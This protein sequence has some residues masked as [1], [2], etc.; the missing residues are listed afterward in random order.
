M[1]RVEAIK[2]YYESE[3]ERIISRHR[4]QSGGGYVS[5]REIM[6]EHTRL[7]DTVIRRLV[8][9][10]I[11]DAILPKDAALTM[12]AL[13]GYGREELNPHSDIDLL[14][15]YDRSGFPEPA[16][17]GTAK[18][19]VTDLWDVGFEVGNV[20]RTI[21]ECRQAAAED[22]E[23][24]T[25]MLEARYILGDQE[26]YKKFEREIKTRAMRKGANRYILNRIEDWQ[27]DLG[28]PNRT[29]YVQEPHIKEGVGG[30]RE[31][32]ISK[33]ISRVRFDLQEIPELASNGI[34]P[35]SAVDDYES[36][37]D[38]L[39]RVRNELHYIAGRRS[40]V[41][42]FQF[43]ER[44]A[45]AL[46][47]ED[48]KR[49]LAEERLMQDYFL[50]ARWIHECARMV[51][52]QSRR[53]PTWISRKMDT[54]NAKPL[55][56]GLIILREKIRFKQ[57]A[58]E[59]A[60]KSGDAAL[61]VME[62][63]YRRAELDILISVA[64]R[65]QIVETLH[66][67]GPKF[68]ACLRTQNRFLEL[69]ELPNGVGDALRD[70]HNLG[71][72]SAMVPE[73]EG[74][75]SLVR[76]DHYHK[77]TTDE[78]TLT[79][80]SNLDDR[81][82]ETAQKN[83][84]LL[85]VLSALNPEERVSL[86][87]GMLL[88][89]IGKGAPGELG[90]VERGMPLTNRILTRLRTLRDGQRDDVM[91]L[92]EKHH[93]KSNTAQRRNLDDPAV[94]ERYTEE[95]GSL[96]RARMLYLLT[97]GDIR[98]VDPELWTG[99]SAALLHKLYA[100]T[101]RCLRGEALVSP[102]QLAALA[103]A[104]VERLG[105]EWKERVHEHFRLMGGGR[106]P[107]YSIR[108][109]AEQA[110]A[111]DEFAGGAS[112]ALRIFSESEA[113]STAVFAAKDRIGM[114]ADLAGALTA[115]GVEIL[116]ADLNSRSDGAAVDTLHFSGDETDGL[117]EQIVEAFEQAQRGELDIDGHIED[118][119]R[120][121]SQKHRTAHTPPMARF[122]NDDSADYTIIDVRAADRIGLLYTI[123][124]TLSDAHLDI[125][126]AKIST[127]AYR[128]VCIFYVADETGAKVQ[129]RERLEAA[130]NALHEAL[131]NGAES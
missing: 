18:R 112:C 79:A 66:R 120:R 49:H 12:V 4:H 2:K 123:A 129:D 87:L 61:L 16:L 115:T 106:M 14:I 11:E 36:A 111:V 46:G 71:V 116:S 44:V 130:V 91:F 101:E 126:L 92:V 35:K 23:S 77:Y 33:W 108:E 62:M 118:R 51:I 70:M 104:S 6:Q 67:V 63:F 94:V 37:L 21:S 95:I 5:G 114:F 17:E 40:D 103:E 58:L 83:G 31:A 32:H 25:A 73:F 28:N 127:A 119:R 107:F 75:R 81:I 99:W 39:W 64:S 41:L 122:N 60:L 102:G 76:Y 29:L 47:Y 9:S 38:F 105:E 26:L 22:G 93:L 96:K 89:D 7:A 54:I 88:H 59:E 10:C 57:G 121:G 110:Q 131:E 30:L 3:R 100:Q 48:S 72:L 97:Y 13:G 52:L 34:L 113:Y 43:Q 19:V 53:E 55:T 56:S 125:S 82:V 27:K 20:A 109:I 24:R 84:E 65:K 78:H 98:A 68:G 86:R 85:P 90:H 80:V 124:K 45:K 42:S 69:L 74:L 8:R 128:S 50:H 117:K 15:L 1:M